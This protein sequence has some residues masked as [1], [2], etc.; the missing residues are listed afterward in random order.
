MKPNINSE[1]CLR[2]DH[3]LCCLLQWCNKMGHW[4]IQYS[5]NL[6]SVNRAETSIFTVWDT[7]SLHDKECEWVEFSFPSEYGPFPSKL[8]C[9]FFLHPWGR[10]C[11]CPLQVPIH[12]HPASAL[13]YFHPSSMQAIRFS[14]PAAVIVHIHLHKTLF[15]PALFTQP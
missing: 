7:Q 2:Q 4:T 1:C 13:S 5:N 6:F 9:S 3:F 10:I 12:H 14:A 8:I 15:A 11:R